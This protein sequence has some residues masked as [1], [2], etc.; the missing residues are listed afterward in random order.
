MGR[1]GPRRRPTIAGSRSPFSEVGPTA[2]RSAGDDNSTS[3]RVTPKRRV[4][5]QGAVDRRRPRPHPRQRP[6]DRRAARVR[7]AACSSGAA[8]CSSSRGFREPSTLG[9]TA[10]LDARPRHR[11]SPPHTLL[12]DARGGFLASTSPSRRSARRAPRRARFVR[13]GRRRRARVNSLQPARSRSTH[14]CTPAVCTPANQRT[15]HVR[16]RRPRARC[17]PCS[18]SGHRRRARTC[19]S[20]RP[21]TIRLRR[22]LPNLELGDRRHARHRVSRAVQPPA[23]A[24][25]LRKRILR[26]DAATTIRR[27]ASGTGP[28]EPLGRRLGEH[29]RDA[30]GPRCLDLGSGSG[31]RQSSVATRHARRVGIR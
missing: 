9:V 4:G 6:A 18:A 11:V 15:S 10:R 22:G 3:C 2:A 5:R 24:M 31:L 26:I 19:S 1:P 27:A 20:R 14:S 23:L 28:L 17:P 13:R 8:R 21:A 12:C 29:H 16:P 7:G 30:A 25:E